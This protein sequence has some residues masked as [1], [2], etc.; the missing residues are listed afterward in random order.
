MKK[1]P[2]IILLACVS[3]LC[4]CSKN[5][6]SNG[7]VH[8]YERM[9]DKPF[10]I[11]EIHDNLDVSLKHCDATYPAGTILIKIGENLYDNIETEIEERLVNNDGDTLRLNALVIR[12]HNTN[13]FLR[14]YDFT[15]ELTIYYDSLLKISLN[16]NADLVQ[17]DTLRGYLMNTHFSNSTSEWDSL[18]ANLLLEVEGGAG[19]FNVLANCYKMMAKYIHGTSTLSIKGE[20]S[21]ASVYADYD[22][23]GVIDCIGLNTHIF[24]VTTHGTNAIKTKTYHLLDINHSNIGVVHYLRYR[25]E[26]E[27]YSWNDSLHQFDTIHKR[28]LCPEIIRFNGGY[29]NIWNYDNDTNSIPGL[30]QDRP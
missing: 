4:S 12:N 25:H 15:R 7:E 2:V 21:I 28:I 8:E 5:P 9:A 20:S 13:N 14:P 18:A 26:T 27:Q 17:T 3:L 11:V 29:I 24:Y 1:A 6:F 23:H 22:C 19:N 10:Q 30:I 16:S